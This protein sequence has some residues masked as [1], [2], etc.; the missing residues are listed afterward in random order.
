MRAYE[1][2]FGMKLGDQDKSW[3]L[4]KVCKHCTE[5]LRFSTQ[6]KVSSM[7]F[8]VFIVWREPKNYHDDCCFY[9]IDMSGWNQRQKK[10]WYYPDIE[11]A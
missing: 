1:V 5:T 3:A 11:S 10:D 6:G 2:Y 8:G 7:L 4:H 9:M